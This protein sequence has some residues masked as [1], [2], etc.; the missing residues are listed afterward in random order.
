METATNSNDKNDAQY[1][2]GINEYLRRYTPEHHSSTPDMLENRYR[3]LLSTPLPEFNTGQAQAYAAEDTREPSGKPLFALVCRKCT[4]Q[5]IKAIEQLKNIRNPCIMTLLAA[6]AVEFSSTKEE[7]YTI[8]YERPAGERLSVLLAR[9]QRPLGEIFIR[10]RII[11]PLVSALQQLSESNVAHGRLNAENIWFESVPVLGD[12]VSEPCGLSQ[13]FYYE[14]LERIQC[15]PYGKGEGNGS[16][17][18]YA[19]ATLTLALLYGPGHFEVFTS[20]NIQGLILRDGEVQALTRNRDYPEVFYEYFRGMFA[21]FSED[22]W[23]HRF[24]KPW[25][26]GKRF[27]LIAGAPAVETSRPFEAGNSLIRN[28]REL[29]HVLANHFED[30]AEGLEN[31]KLAHWTSL[32]M[33][34]KE[35]AETFNRISRYMN[36]QN[37]K[38]A[39]STLPELLMKA[40]LQVDPRG[41][42]RLKTLAFMPDGLGS[43]VAHLFAEN[44][45][46]NLQLV[47]RFISFSMLDFWQETQRQLEEQKFRSREYAPQPHISEV[48]TQIDRLRQSSRNTGL[49]FGPERML[50][51]LNP[52]IPCQSPA[53]ARWHITTI[54]DLLKRLDQQAHNLANNEDPLDRHIAAFIYSK[55][56]IQHEQH[57]HTLEAVP[58]LATHRGMIALSILSKAYQLRS[59]GLQLPGLTHWLVLRIL[60]VLENI[61]SAS[62]RTILKDGLVDEA[63]S[64]NLQH[65]SDILLSSNYLNSD[66]QGFNK[67]KHKYTRNAQRIAYYKNPRSAELSSAILGARVAK[68]IAYIALLI[69]VVMLFWGH[70]A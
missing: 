2:S 15:H 23:N 24:I 35:I 30:I 34:N 70:N 54:P 17:D 36:S 7:R 9:Q 45:Q 63:P 20:E 27:N 5:R 44:Q 39:D 56:S 28:R 3:I 25:L 10:E 37:S 42:I 12:C 32:Y 14:P 55:F 68:F 61:R 26:E 66:K 48:I 52:T 38:Q 46:A 33:R 41:P 1:L 49:G 21:P 22:R 31:G 11:T 64:G 59:S 51:D 50:Y 29:A 69:S 13:I 62:L 65:I 67:A 4:L 43:L 8:V 16:Q 53:L 40:I 6:G 58:L 60:P 57:L 18:Y 47:N 19:L